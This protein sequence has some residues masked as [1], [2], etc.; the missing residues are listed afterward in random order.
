MLIPCPFCGPRETTEFVYFGDATALR[1][2][3]KADSE[4]WAAAV[5]DRSNPKGTHREWW[6]HV[7]GCRSLVEVERDT[8]S[9]RISGSRLVPEIREGRT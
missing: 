3:L 6:L 7:A 1:P 4:T 8:T 5:F 2:A 9:H